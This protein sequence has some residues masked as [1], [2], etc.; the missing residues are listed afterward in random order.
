MTSLS[1]ALFY[2]LGLPEMVIV[3]GV[4]LLFFGA[5]KVPELAKSLGTGIREF[6]KSLTMESEDD[7]DL[8][9]STKIEDTEES[10]SNTQ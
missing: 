10:K 5:K 6:K 9:K 8:E 2:N 1:L 3:F 7:D 4:I